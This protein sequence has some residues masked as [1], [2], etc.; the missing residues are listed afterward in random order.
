MILKLSFEFTLRSI[1]LPYKQL[2]V[3][4]KKEL[5][6]W[7]G[8]LLLKKKSYVSL[9][10]RNSASYTVVLEEVYLLGEVINAKILLVETM[11]AHV[12]VYHYV[13]SFQFWRPCRSL[14]FKRFYKVSRMQE[15]STK[16]SADHPLGPQYSK[17]RAN[18][19]N[20]N[21]DKVSVMKSI[22]SWLL[23]VAVQKMHKF[24]FL[25]IL[26]RGKFNAYP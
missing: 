17:W 11:G 23:Q 7:S 1:L 22:L 8:Y 3:L 26:L 13:W 25:L 10:T 16:M 20:V 14:P 6:A 2:T 4:E 12:K 9:K 15:W 5:T 19:T 24:W 21:D 18:W